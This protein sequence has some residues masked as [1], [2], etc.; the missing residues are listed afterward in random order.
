M[1]LAC[2]MMCETHL[3]GPFVKNFCSRTLQL[4]APLY[5]ARQLTLINWNIIFSCLLRPLFCFSL[6]FVTLCFVSTHLHHSA[7][8]WAYTKDER[9]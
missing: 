7:A 2:T 1:F 4:R 6:R 5:R 9:K 3:P 8:T